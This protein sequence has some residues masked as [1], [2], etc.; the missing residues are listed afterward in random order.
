[1]PV[2]SEEKDIGGARY[3]VTQLG[4]E[5]ASELMFRLLRAL[6]MGLVNVS[7]APSLRDLG[8]AIRALGMED[9]IEFRSAF[10]AETAV[11]VEDRAKKT[12][13]KARWM[14]MTTVGFDAQ[15]AGNPLA[16]VQWFRFAFEVNFASFFPD[17]L[18]RASAPGEGM[19]ETTL[20]ESDSPEPST[21]TSGASSRADA[22]P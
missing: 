3:R 10:A 19:Q 12:G 14:P 8:G 2:K 18:G 11:L 13:I 15:F 21:G 4:G 9:F 5:K 1:M 6:G 16:L 22:S 20:S 17:L 7:G